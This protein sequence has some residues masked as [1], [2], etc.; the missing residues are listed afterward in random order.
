MGKTS[1]ICAL[2]I[3]INQRNSLLQIEVTIQYE[4]NPIIRMRITCSQ[5]NILYLVFFKFVCN[6]KIMT[7]HP[8]L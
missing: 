4:S 2:A 3:Y 7:I 6:F 1:D 5:T 8:S